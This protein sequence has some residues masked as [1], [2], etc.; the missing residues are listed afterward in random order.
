MNII[1]KLLFFQVNLKVG[2]E[3]VGFQN[4]AP[5]LLLTDRVHYFLSIT[6]FF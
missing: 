1:R 4:L 2:S 6:G 3:G 5:S